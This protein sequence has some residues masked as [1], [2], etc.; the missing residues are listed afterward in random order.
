MQSD[1]GSQT[2]GFFKF[3][4]IGDFLVQMVDVFIIFGA[5]AVFF[6]F[7]LGGIEWLTSGGDKVKVE[8]AQKKIT[9]AVVGLAILSVT[10]VLYKIIL[11]FF[12]LEE[13]IQLPG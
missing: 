1:I 9:G 8:T 5:I 2:Q 13:A 11:R 3:Q 4:S 12:G 10:Y 6:Y 7:F